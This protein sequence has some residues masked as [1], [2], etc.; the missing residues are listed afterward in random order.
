MRHLWKFKGEINISRPITVIHI[1]RILQFLLVIIECS[2][3]IQSAD[4]FPGCYIFVARLC[5]TV[6]RRNFSRPITVYPHFHQHLLLVIIE[7]AKEIQSADKFPGCYG[8]LLVLVEQFKGEINISRPITEIHISRML[9]FCSSSLKVQR[10]FKLLTNFQVVNFLWL[11]FVEQF[12][13]TKE[14]YFKTQY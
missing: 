3:E 13:L 11:V 6:Q 7:C 8:F 9:H 4:K 10:R 2:Q 5:W 14:K 12:N 1:S